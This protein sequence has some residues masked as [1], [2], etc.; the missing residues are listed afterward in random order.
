MLHNY[1]H[2]VHF[3]FNFTVLICYIGPGKKDTGDWCFED[4][5]I[6][7]RDLAEL[8]CNCFKGCVLSIRAD[9]S[10]SGRWVKELMKF[11]EEQGVKP[12]G[13]SA[14]ETGILI[15]VFAS[16]KPTEIPYRLLYSLRAQLND[17]NTGMALVKYSGFEVA[18]DQH[19]HW[20]D[21][22]ILK[23]NAS[24][25]EEP[26]T[27][28][29]EYTWERWETRDRIKLV[30]GNDC[31]RPVWHYVQL[32]DDEEKIKEFKELTMGGK[33]TMD[34]SKYGQVIKSGWGKDPS[35]DVK[36]WMMKHYG[37]N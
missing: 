17:K 31:G 23:C 7:F 16:C 29:P 25:F 34:V 24:S 36:E 32:T 30:T 33:H 14:R 15:K 27:F 4:G 6:T 5:F 21:P 22:T 35:D 13:H 8:Y 1:M 19:I 11:L 28:S 9:C 2:G 18:K 26:C 3:H 12:C 20:L 10:Y 37:L